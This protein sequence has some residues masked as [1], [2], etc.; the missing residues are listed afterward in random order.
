[1]IVDSDVCVYAARGRGQFPSRGIAY[2]VVVLFIGV[3]CAALGF[4]MCCEAC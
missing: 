3:A 4:G 1:M 2:A